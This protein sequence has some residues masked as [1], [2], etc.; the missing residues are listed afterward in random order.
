MSH[1]FNT[2]NETDKSLSLFEDKA[3]DQEQK[4]ILYLQKEQIRLFTSETIKDNV[5]TDSTPMTSVRRA[6]T[7]LKDQGY[8]IDSTVRVKSKSKRNIVQW[9]LV[10][11]AP[12]DNNKKTIRQKLKEVNDDTVTELLY[13][14]NKNGLIVES[15]ED[16]E[17]GIKALKEYLLN[18]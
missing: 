7:K 1:Y 8:I 13:T 2:A 14:I 10:S 4:I 12:T 9:K 15:R 5:F 6:I 3:K 17:E 11:L 16:F 18:N